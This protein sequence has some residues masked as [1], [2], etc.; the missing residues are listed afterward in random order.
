MP[1]K[2]ST[3]KVFKIWSHELIKTMPVKILWL[4]IQRIK[5]SRATLPEHHTIWLPSLK[6][7]TWFAA[8]LPATV[9]GYVRE[10]MTETGLHTQ[11]YTPH[12][13]TSATSTKAIQ[14]S[15]TVIDVKM[16]ANWSLDSQTFEKYYLKPTHLESRSAK[17]LHSI[18]PRTTE[19]YTT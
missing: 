1:T 2:R 16:H 12:T 9:A 11:L 17:L 3:I 14:N 10:M 18:F 5:D 6:Q 8:A 19:D 13:L 7:E 4:Y 15:N